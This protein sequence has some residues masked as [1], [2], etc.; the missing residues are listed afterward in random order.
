VASLPHGAALGELAG[1]A[2]RGRLVLTLDPKDGGSIYQGIVAL[3]AGTVAGV[4]EH[5]L[6][7]SE[8]LASRLVLAADDED[9][10]GFLLQ[11]L[12]G[13]DDAAAWAATT[14]PLADIDPA[15]L[16]TAG[17][18]TDVIANMLPEHEMR[19][20]ASRPVTFHC[21]CSR[22]RVENALRIAGSAEVE[23]I[24]AE[25]GFVDVTC[26][27]CNRSYVFTPVEARGAF[28]PREGH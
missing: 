2:D 23:S 22:E 9:A 28:A 4:I 3:E 18:A 20:F 1:G 27:F 8:Q 10:A 14:A 17:A 12:P 16:L 19:V 15:S 25:K 11:R 7:T 5:Y 13:S 6:A 21:S 26:E 24:L